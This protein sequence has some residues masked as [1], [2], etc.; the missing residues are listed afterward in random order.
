MKP[1]RKQKLKMLQCSEEKHLKLINFMKTPQE[2]K[3]MEKQ[4]KGLARFFKIELTI[5]IFDHVI[6]KW[7]YPPKEE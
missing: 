6:V 2:Q 3:E 1:K 4:A 5:S 7:T